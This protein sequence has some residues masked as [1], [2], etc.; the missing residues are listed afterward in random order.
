MIWNLLTAGIYGVDYYAK[1]K[2]NTEVSRG[3]KKEIAGGKLF[4]RNCHNDGMV[5]GTLKGKDKDTVKEVSTMVLGGVIWEYIRNMGA[6]GKEGS[7]TAK[8]GLSMAL[9]GGLNNYMERRKTGSVTDYISLNTE[10]K[11]L[12]KLVFNISDLFIFAG[13][14]LWGI[15]MI[16]SEKTK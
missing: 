13:A 9:G 12:R 11:K 16:F 4:L 7:R 2:V 1:K 14:A 8:L 10:D 5:F 15:S 3:S 6:A